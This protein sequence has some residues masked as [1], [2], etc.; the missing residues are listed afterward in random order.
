MLSRFYELREVFIIMYPE[1]LD[2]YDWENLKRL[3]GVLKPL[4]SA[5]VLLQHTTANH[6]TA[7]AVIKYL[8]HIASTEPLLN[9]PVKDTLEKWIDDNDI[10]KAIFNPYGDDNVFC[11]KIKDYVVSQQ[12][13]TQLPAAEH[14]YVSDDIIPLDEFLEE[15][16]DD[17]FDV[18]SHMKN[19]RPSSSDAE[20][21]FSLCRLNRNYLQN[22]MSVHHHRRNVFLNKNYAFFDE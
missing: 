8:R 13:N 14:A 4:Q 3:L 21:L 9:S 17:E 5:S 1:E 15:V 19:F 10:V 2:F 7:K 16:Q 18:R 22:C 6:A 20:R 12:P 11:K